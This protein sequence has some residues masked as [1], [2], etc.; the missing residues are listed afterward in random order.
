[1]THRDLQNQIACVMRIFHD[2][3]EAIKDAQQRT[4]EQ[5]APFVVLDFKGGYAT[6]SAMQAGSLSKS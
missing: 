1:M 2:R 5:G 6:M 3:D 4:Q